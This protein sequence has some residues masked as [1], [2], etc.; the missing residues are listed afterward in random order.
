MCVCQLVNARDVQLKHG[1][2]HVCVRE[3]DVIENTLCMHVLLVKLDYVK[4]IVSHVSMN[5]LTIVCNSVLN[6][7]LMNYY[8]YCF[9]VQWCT[10]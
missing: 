1:R 2:C 8:Y 6:I 4:L 3:R 7:K 10:L 5:N 9:L